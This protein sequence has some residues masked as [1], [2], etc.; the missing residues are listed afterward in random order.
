MRVS[1]GNVARGLPS[2]A[3]LICIRHSADCGEYYRRMVLRYLVSSSSWDKEA[4]QQCTQFTCPFV[5]ILVVQHSAVVVVAQWAT[6]AEHTCHECKA[7][8]LTTVALR[9]C[10]CSRSLFSSSYYAA[11][12]SLSTLFLSCWYLR[13]PISSS[14]PHLPN[15]SALAS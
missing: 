4:R 10:H 1:R 15:M 14:P 9:R 2:W 11:I 5:C 13:I 3:V 7:E 6:G 12:L 8:C